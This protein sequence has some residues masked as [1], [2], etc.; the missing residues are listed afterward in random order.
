MASSPST[1]IGAKVAVVT[2][3]RPYWLSMI[4]TSLFMARGSNTCSRNT[5][6]VVY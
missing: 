2:F 3:S 6:V 5:V 4:A 1:Y